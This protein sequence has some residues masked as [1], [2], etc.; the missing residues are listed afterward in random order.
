MDYFLMLKIIG[1]GMQYGALITDYSKCSTL[2]LKTSS[3]H[4]RISLDHLRSVYYAVWSTTRQM[5]PES[6]D[7][8]EFLGDGVSDG[9]LSLCSAHC[10]KDTR[11]RS[12]KIVNLSAE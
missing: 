9:A 4:T 6:A 3:R 5:C 10:K 2:T 8:M 12:R 1:A 11:T 7:D